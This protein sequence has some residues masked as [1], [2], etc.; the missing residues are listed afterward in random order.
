MP[1]DPFAKLHRDDD[2]LCCF[3]SLP[4]F[5]VFGKG[6]AQIERRYQ[7]AEAAEFP[8]VVEQA[9]SALKSA[10]QSVRVREIDARLDA[11]KQDDPE[12]WAALERM[13]RGEGPAARAPATRPS[14]KPIAPATPRG[15]VILCLGEVQQPTANQRRQFDW[16]I[17]NQASVAQDFRRK[18][19]AFY[20][21]RTGSEPKE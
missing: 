3:A 13:M 12:W 2:D 18:L 17:A 7:A 15:E 6:Y 20:E 21:E 11:M 8:A 9:K 19:Y 5:K 4:A 14:P 1:S 10:A 16:L